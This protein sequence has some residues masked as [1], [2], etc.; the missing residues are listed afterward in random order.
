MRW[1]GFRK[2]GV[3]MH[4]KQLLNITSQFPGWAAYE[5]AMRNL[6]WRSSKL[7]MVKNISI[8]EKFLAA[9]HSL[10]H[11]LGKEEMLSIW[12][13]DIEPYAK[14]LEGEWV[15]NIDISK[16]IQAKEEKLRIGVAIEHMYGALKTVAGVNDTNTSKLLH[17]RLPHLFVM[18]DGDVRFLFKKLRNETFLPY[19]YAFN[20]LEFV[21]F[22][23]NEAINTLCEDE[24]LTRQQ[25]IKSLQNSHGTQRPLT[26]LMDECYYTLAHHPEKFP[27]EYFVTLARRFK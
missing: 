3:K 14:V 10:R 6:E 2:R 17:L 26:K 27:K 4:Y 21:K 5:E 9:S 7:D 8:F 25:G 13:K 20:F 24:H 22:D 12:T 19:S 18:T 15:E 16:M 1:G 23:V 11:E